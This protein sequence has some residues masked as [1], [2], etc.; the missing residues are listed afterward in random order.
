MFLTG[1]L[2]EGQPAGRAW[3]E[4]GGGCVRFL[5]IV[6]PDLDFGPGGIAFPIGRNYDE[7]VGAGNAREDRRAAGCERFDLAGA[8]PHAG[9]VDASHNRGQLATKGYFLAAIRPMLWSPRQP[10][11]DRAG[12]EIVGAQAAYGISRHEDHGQLAVANETEPCGACRPQRE[13]MSDQPPHF[14]DDPRHVVFRAGG[15]PAGDD[16]EVDPRGK[17]G[18]RGGD[19]CSD[20]GDGP[21]H[22]TRTAIPSDQGCDHHGVHVGDLN[23]AGFRSCGEQLVAGDQGGDAGSPDHADGGLAQGA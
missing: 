4:T 16:Q 10:A 5:L 13:S 20:V 6:V 11:D 1:R 21:R 9:V 7:P 14:G 22:V 2:I 17:L 23:T 18:D 19:G 3:L 15:A 8:D 12:D